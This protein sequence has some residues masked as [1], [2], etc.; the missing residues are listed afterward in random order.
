MYTLALTLHSYT[1]W[2]VIIAMLWALVMAWSGWLRPRE[3]TQWD[4]RA[5]LFFS[6]IF[7]IQFI[8]GV[9]LVL[10][11]VGFAQAAWRDMGAA[12]QVRDLRFFGLEHPLQMIIAL[13]LVHLGRARS[14]KATVTSKKFRWAA[15]TFTIASLLVLAAIP[16]WR[17]LLRA[18]TAYI[19]IPIG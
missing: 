3:W 7:S 2:L 8:L 18:I 6:T 16:W 19:G 1:R 9:I 14:R 13:T 17:P 11:P 15:I 4:N 12:M 5:G 10:Q